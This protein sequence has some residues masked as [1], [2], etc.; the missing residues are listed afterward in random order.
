[1]SQIVSFNDHVPF[2]DAVKG[3]LLQNGENVILWFIAALFIYSVGFYFVDKVCTTPIWL[4]VL[5]AILFILNSITYHWLGV[6][7]IPWHLA[8]FGFAIFYMA[9]GKLYRLYEKQIDS[10]L[11]LPVLAVFLV[12]YIAAI[13]FAGRDIYISFYG[14]KYIV[15]SMIL[16]LMGII[17]I[18]SLSKSISGKWIS[19]I[20][21]VG[22]NSLF[23]FAFHGKA[24]SF[25]FSL[26]NK[27]YPKWTVINDVV[28]S[29]FVIIMDILIL[30]LPGMAMNKYCPFVFGKGFKLWKA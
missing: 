15:D 14:S 10:F 16:T 20:L 13:Y 22:A 8:T 18:I 30:I 3:L 2:K 11:T 26:M 12:V 27:L 29:I 5:S 17:L 9:L 1:M 4:L 6:K 23:Y 25:V 21:F 19:M 24:Y 7:F 28:I